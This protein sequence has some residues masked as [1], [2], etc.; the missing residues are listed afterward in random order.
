MGSCCGGLGWFGGFGW[1]GAFMNFVILLAIL[2][3]VVWFVIWLAQR[4]RRSGGNPAR[5]LCSWWNFPR[6]VWAND[7]RLV[8]M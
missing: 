1:L 3:G 4:G 7:A 6:W 8:A 5:S 2:G